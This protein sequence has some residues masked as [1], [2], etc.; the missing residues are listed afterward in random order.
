MLRNLAK[1]TTVNNGGSDSDVLER[2]VHP[3]LLDDTPL[4]N[5]TA[6]NLSALTTLNLPKGVSNATPSWGVLESV[7][8]EDLPELVSINVQ[9]NSLESVVLE[10]LP[11]LVSI[12]VHAATVCRG[13]CCL[14]CRS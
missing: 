4:R 1:I 10:D 13:W 12:N 6:V 11:E 5:F 8:L 14:F 2:P 3:V 7:V 9:Q